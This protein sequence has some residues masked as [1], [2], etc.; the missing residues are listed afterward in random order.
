MFSVKNICIL[1]YK[2]ERPTYRSVIRWLKTS[3]SLKVFTNSPFRMHNT[4][5]RC[6]FRQY[7]QKNCCRSKLLAVNT[8]WLVEI[9]YIH[10]LYNTA[11]YWVDTSIC[12]DTGAS[13]SEHIPIVQCSTSTNYPS[14]SFFQMSN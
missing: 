1:F 13:K 3:F 6:N 2:S 10:L 5:G 12:S 4:V 8:L 11:P 14:V 9:S 7:M